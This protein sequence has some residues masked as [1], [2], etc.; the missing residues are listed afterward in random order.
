LDSAPKISRYKHMRLK[1]NTYNFAK[2]PRVG[3]R[4]SCNTYLNLSA[5]RATMEHQDTE[6]LIPSEASLATD[7][8]QSADRPYVWWGVLG[9]IAFAL[10]AI[11]I[12]VAIP[13]A[14]LVP[15][16][17]FAQ[18]SSAQ[19]DCPATQTG[20]G[21]VGN[22]DLY[23]LG[24]RAGIYLQWISSIIVNHFLSSQI[25][26]YAATNIVFGFA[27]CVALLILTLRGDCTYI[28]EVIVLMFMF[29]GGIYPLVDI[30]GTQASSPGL[31]YGWYLLGFPMY[32]FTC[33]FWIRLAA[34]SGYHYALTPCGTSFFLFKQVHQH[35]FVIA[36]RFM[37]FFC[38]WAPWGTL[39]QGYMSR[40]FSRAGYPKLSTVVS[41][42]TP[43]GIGVMIISS[44]RFGMQFMLW[45]ILKFFGKEPKNMSE[46][47]ILDQM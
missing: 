27:V 10:L 7:G 42:L 23:G 35:H 46:S 2:I 39:I 4:I 20:C 19:R 5:S 32:L 30:A 36:S 24:I 15:L 21:F 14:I 11:A 45:D 6:R 41:L 3:Q 44:V 18:R 25:K 13:A 37:A 38:F 28:A 17:Y 12:I 22:S 40:I 1:T 8:S 26:N 31:K 34:G 33:W 29:W 16:V 9:T 47:K 43:V